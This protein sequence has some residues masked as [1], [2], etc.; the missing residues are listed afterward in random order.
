[1]T[2][3]SIQTLETIPPSAL[4]RRGYRLTQPVPVSVVETPKGFSVTTKGPAVILLATAP[5][6][7]VAK[8]QFA[9]GLVNQ[10]GLSENALKSNPNNGFH[11]KVAAS[12]KEYVAPAI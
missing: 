6:K 1:M 8:R 5:T 9:S 12:I 10:L 3:V 4:R 2:M 11:K 7:E